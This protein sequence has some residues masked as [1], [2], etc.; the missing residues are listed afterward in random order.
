MMCPPPGDAV[1]RDY[2]AALA[3]AADFRVEG[4]LLQLLTAEGT[5]VASYTRAPSE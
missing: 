3:M 1:E 2:L 5:Q 4:R